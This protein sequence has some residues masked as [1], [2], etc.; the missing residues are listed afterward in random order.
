LNTESYAAETANRLWNVAHEKKITSY[1]F[2]WES[3]IDESVLGWLKSDDDVTGPAGFSWH[4]AW[5]KIQKGAGKVVREDQRK[6]GEGLAPVARKVFWD[7]MKGR[8]QGAST[9]NG[10]AALFTGEL[11]KAI[12]RTPGEKYKFHLVAHS[13][14]SI[15]LG[16]LYQDVLTAL[17]AATPNAEL[18]S[19]QFMAPAIS[20]ERAKEAFST[21]G[22]FAVPRERLVVYMLK[23]QDEQNDSIYV[24]PSSLLTYVA[25]HLE[26]DDARIPIFGIRQDFND[27][28]INFAT[29]VQA[30]QS[31]RHGEFND[32]RHEVEEIFTRISAVDF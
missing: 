5:D 10:G 14:G 32:A 16:W 13:A 8:A 19:V 29:P 2:V 21:N 26:D 23:S 7:E 24:Y 31:I 22:N 3:G 30:S 11:F 27:A 1:F 15:Y 4:D 12:S 25:D 28:N 20:I 9:R 6:L 17:L 18:A